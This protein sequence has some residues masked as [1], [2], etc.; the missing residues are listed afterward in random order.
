MPD[1]RPIS[2]RLRVGRGSDAGGQG[3]YVS[4]VAGQ[5]Q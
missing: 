3:Q 2:S 4:V 5:G 1:T